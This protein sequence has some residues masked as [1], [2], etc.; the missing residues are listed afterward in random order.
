MREE[1]ETRPLDEV[2]YAAPMDVFPELF[3]RFL[4]VPASLRRALCEVHGEI[5]DPAWWRT[6]QQRLQREYVDV[7]PYPATARLR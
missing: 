7:M 6:M 4:G 2:L 1:D 3:V 5:F